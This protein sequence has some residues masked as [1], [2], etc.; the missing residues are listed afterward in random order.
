MNPADFADQARSVLADSAYQTDFPKAVLPEPPDEP[1]AWLVELLEK[2]AEVMG[3]LFDSVPGIDMSGAGDGLRVLLFLLLAC[4][5]LA[6]LFLLVRWLAPMIGRRSDRLPTAVRSESRPPT[7]ARILLA[8][9]RQAIADGDLDRAAGYLLEAVL[10]ALAE[11]TGQRH[12]EAD[13]ARQILHKIRVEAT[14]LELL[15]ALVTLRERAHYAG[16]PPAGP[17]LDAMLTR[18]EAI[19]DGA[20]AS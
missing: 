1:P 13:T 7:P 11:K 2:I 12:R 6:G 10:A 3:G 20:V 15:R 8:S 17:E 16:R 5:V 19:I 9:A 14:T 4:I 18:S